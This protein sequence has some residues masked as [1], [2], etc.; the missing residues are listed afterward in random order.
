MPSNVEC[1]SGVE[2]PEQPRKFLWQEH[3]HTVERIYARRR[4][5]QGKQFEIV[6]RG[7]EKFL[8]T[9]DV[10]TDRWTIQPIQ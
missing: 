2:Y 3:W 4:T 1:Y 6:D 9:Y 5:V 10:L 8:L 7:G